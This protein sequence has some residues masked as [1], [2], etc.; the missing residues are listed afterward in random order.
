MGIKREGISGD[1]LACDPG[2]MYQ[3][4]FQPREMQ[5]KKISPSH[6]PLGSHTATAPSPGVPKTTA[7]WDAGRIVRRSTR[8][9]R[10]EASRRRSGVNLE[11]D[12]S[13]I[14]ELS[15][16][17]CARVAEAEEREEKRTRDT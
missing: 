17:E 1:A 13:R 5:K 4:P 16:K 15:E 14:M 6:A 12:T 11:S 9:R 7:P 10:L 8:H 2:L 3:D